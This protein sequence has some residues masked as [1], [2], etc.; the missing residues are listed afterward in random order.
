[1]R[2]DEH[3]QY[4]TDFVRLVNQ[5][6]S[7]PLLIEPLFLAHIP[8]FEDEDTALKKIFKSSITPEI[9]IADKE[10]N[11]TF[12]GM[13]DA[14]KSMLNHFIEAKSNA[15][16]R[17]KPVFD[18]YGN[19]TVKPLN[20]QSSGIYNMIQELNDNYA[21]ECEIIGI[22]TWIIALTECNNTLTNLMHSRYTE[23]ASRTSIVLKEARAKV[24]V[25]YRAMVDRINANV[26]LNGAGYSEEFIRRLNAII[27]RYSAIIAQR[28]SKSGKK[29]KEEEE[30]NN[31]QQ[32]QE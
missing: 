17:I 5:F 4:N 14:Y 2:N 29:A 11:S 28:Y 32:P 6:G 10:V 30:N 1:M 20:E 23:I 24:D 21:D 22:D 7:L 16:K 13:V 18:T 8:L 12:R 31:D 15:A 25:S 27:D 19:L 9:K 3:F 26:T